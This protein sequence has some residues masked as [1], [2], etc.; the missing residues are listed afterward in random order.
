MKI[1][2]VNVWLAAAWSRHVKHATAKNWVDTE[3]GELAFCRVTQMALR[4]LLTNPAITGLDAMTRHQA[5]DAYDKLIADPRIRLVAEPEGLDALWVTFSKRTDRSHLLWTD[6]YL[7]AFT[8]ASGAEF[9]TL[10]R[11][12]AKRYPSLQTTYL[13]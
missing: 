13:P 1:P 9:V 4:R 6:D 8:Q 7:A 10:D 3:P 2:D 12:F 5:W 11:A